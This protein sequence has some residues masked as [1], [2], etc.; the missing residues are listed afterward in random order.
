MMQSDELSE[1]IVSKIQSEVPEQQLSF[2]QYVEYMNRA[3]ATKPEELKQLGKNDSS[4]EE[5]TPLFNEQ[6]NNASK[7]EVRL[8]KQKLDQAYLNQSLMWKGVISFDNE[9]LAK[10]GLYD[11]ETKKVNQDI[12][13]NAVRQSMP[14]L[15]KREGI[16]QSAFWWGDIHH[17]TDNIHV[18]IGISEIQSN[19]EKIYYAPRNQWEYKGQFSQKSLRTMKSKVYHQL[20]SLDHKT[21]ILCQEQQIAN[22][23]T[24]LVTELAEVIRQPDESMLFFL[25]QAYQYLPQDKKWRYGSN[26]I[27]MKKSKFFLEQFLKRYYAKEGSAL[28][29]EFKEANQK[30][31]VN[32]EQAYTSVE[33]NREYEHF[34]VI[35]GVK[36]S[37]TFTTV[38]S[39]VEESLTNRMKLLNERLAN[40]ILQY[41]KDHPP[42]QES[43]LSNFSKINQN[44]VKIVFPDAK[45]IHQ[46]RSW[47]KQGYRLKPNAKSVE[48]LLCVG[49]EEGKPIFKEFSYYDQSQV[50][51]V[52]ARRPSLSQ[53]LL[54]EE[55]ELVEYIELL[56]TMEGTNAYIHKAELGIYRYAL[57]Q[58]GLVAQEE[59]LNKVISRLREVHPIK[60]DEP[61]LNVIKSEYQE[62]LQL[63]RLQRKPNYLLNKE[64][65]LEKMRLNQ[66][67]QNVIQ[68]PIEKAKEAYIQGR[69]DELIEKEK[70]A[71]QV[72]DHS[73]FQVLIPAMKK[74]QYLESLYLQRRILQTKGRIHENNETLKVVDDAKL[75]QENGKLFNHLKEYY[76]KLEG[77]NIESNFISERYFDKENIETQ[78]TWKVNKQQNG[79]AQLQNTS[80]VSISK[81]YLSQLVR[82]LNAAKHR[83]YQ[84]L[85]AKVRADERE[86]REEKREERREGRSR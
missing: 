69:V 1:E 27:D 47:E 20:L 34:K 59:Q 31:L 16:E 38:G 85:M 25:Q 19:R 68:L 78:Y 74:S 84:A 10:E 73:L 55:E 65:Q 2:Q 40:Q 21:K 49:K 6:T 24:D 12:I 83:N 45:M 70:R 58:K 43:N 8:L 86:E 51:L 5:L 17:N 75:R 37:E 82:S 4:E 11:K 48:L 72:Q 32:F 63:V 18:H 57:R 42:E 7:K 36:Q 52:E 30:L 61:F 54:M 62:R 67:Y 79:S 28:Y 29:S 76:A 35:D 13:K 60:S 80:T 39:K 22:L 23:R 71:E 14:E 46:K 15:L 77:K 26:A 50:E 3:Y 33:K 64:E 81:N 9:F 41:F 53:M 56:K 66:K 44:R